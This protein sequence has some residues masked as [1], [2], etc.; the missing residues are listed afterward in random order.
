[1]DKLN[2]SE[3][4]VAELSPIEQGKRL[5]GYKACECLRDGM[6]IGLGTGSTAFYAIE[7]TGQLVAEGLR[8][9][10][11]ATSEATA[12]LAAARNIPLLSA[13]AV[14]EL[15]VAIDGVDEIDPQFNAIKGGGGALFREK[16]IA[17]MSKEVIWVM[18]ERKLVPAIGDFHLPVEILP[19]GASSL[20]YKIDHL[21]LKP[22]LRC[23]RGEELPDWTCPTVR[24]QIEVLQNPSESK[25]LWV[26]DNGNL[27]VDLMVDAP[28]D[29]GYIQKNLLPLTGVLET[30]LFLNICARMYV[31][32]QGTV[33]E[34]INPSPAKR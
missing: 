4:A 18:D 28:L 24:R 6:L 27:L 1:M 7:R 10:A 26:T 34:I 17:M 16:I 29:L 3:S 23:R 12:K 11:V 9:K 20:I 5:A 13:D 25:Q 30:G 31:G 19:F 14:T 33:R 22:R 21:G 8:I 32:G 2:S 15:D